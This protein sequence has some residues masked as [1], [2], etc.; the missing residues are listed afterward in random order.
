MTEEEER[1]L[2]L[3]TSVLSLWLKWLKKNS[4]LLN[5][6]YS[7]SRARR[8]ELLRDEIARRKLLGEK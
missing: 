3:H 1:Y 2:R 6:G 7:M 4:T 5:P 8:I